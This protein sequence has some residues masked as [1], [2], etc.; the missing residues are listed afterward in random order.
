MSWRLC[1]KSSKYVYLPKNEVATKSLRHEE[2]LSQV[3]FEIA[4]LKGDELF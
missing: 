1:G 3:T 4:Q 2:T